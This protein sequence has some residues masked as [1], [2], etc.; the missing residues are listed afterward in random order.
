MLFAAL[1]LMKRK[2][3]FIDSNQ[4]ISKNK[5]MLFSNSEIEYWIDSL[6]DFDGTLIRLGLFYA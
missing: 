1:K 5:I 6:I 3:C 2:K 4:N